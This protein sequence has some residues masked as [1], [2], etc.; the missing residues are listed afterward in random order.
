MCSRREGILWNKATGS[1]TCYHKPVLRSGPYFRATELKDGLNVRA[2]HIAPEN[3]AVRTND[4]EGIA[5]YD[6]KCRPPSDH[7]PVL[8]SG[9]YSG[10][11]KLK[12]RLDL[13]SRDL[14]SEN[15]TVRTNDYQS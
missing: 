10:P 15:E 11:A 4:H 8:R 9:P 1:E 14:G 5:A 7:K 13:S 2:H 6:P 3:K 12:H